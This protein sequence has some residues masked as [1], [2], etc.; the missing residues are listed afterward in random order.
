M[1]TRLPFVK[2]ATEKLLGPMV[3]PGVSTSIISVRVPSGSRSPTLIAIRSSFRVVQ[4]ERRRSDVRKRIPRRTGPC[5]AARDRRATSRA[6][7]F[8]RIALAQRR[9]DLGGVA[10]DLH[11]V[12]AVRD[13]A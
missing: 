8:A 9:E 11:V 12:P 3:Q 10:I 7:A 1:T 13:L 6:G 4:C 5:A 2:S